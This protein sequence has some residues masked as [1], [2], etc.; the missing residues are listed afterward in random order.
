MIHPTRQLSF[1]YPQSKLCVSES[2]AAVDYNNAWSTETYEWNVFRVAPYPTVSA[3][4]CVTKH[5]YM[6]LQCI[7]L[8]ADQLSGARTSFEDT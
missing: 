3:E 4:L 6:D 5:L 8:L 2:T 1:T 7:G